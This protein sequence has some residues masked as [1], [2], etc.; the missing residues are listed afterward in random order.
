MLIFLRYSLRRIYFRVFSF[1]ICNMT[2]WHIQIATSFI[3]TRKNQLGFQSVFINAF[4][5]LTIIEIVTIERCRIRCN[6]QRGALYMKFKIHF[7][8]MN[9]KTCTKKSFIIRLKHKQ[10]TFLVS[11]YLLANTS[12]VFK[13]PRC[14]LCSP[15]F[16]VLLL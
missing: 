6:L 16:R 1:Q 3:V 14:S 11:C 10:Q 4:R 13:H 12:F 7:P 15:F 9:I 2:H 8:W 5:N